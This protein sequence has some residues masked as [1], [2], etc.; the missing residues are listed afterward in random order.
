VRC[1]H[2]LLFS[3]PADLPP[4]SK[5]KTDHGGKGYSRGTGFWEQS[6][7]A[8]VEDRDLGFTGELDKGRPGDEVRVMEDFRDQNSVGC[9]HKVHFV[10]CKH[11]L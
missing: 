1:G 4:L 11:Y 5:M 6:R 7:R 10:H 8:E 3:S 9:F 2:G